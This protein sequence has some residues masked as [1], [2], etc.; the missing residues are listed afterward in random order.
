MMTKAKTHGFSQ[1]AIVIMIIIFIMNL[2]LSRDYNLLRLVL[3]GGGEIV[4]Y[5][6]ESYT[7]VFEYFHFIDLLHMDILKLQYGTYW[8]MFWG[9]GMLEYTLKKG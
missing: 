2:I 8:L 9:Y 5:L 1:I 6:G 4:N 7:T 3:S